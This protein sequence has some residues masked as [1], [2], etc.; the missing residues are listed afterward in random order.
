MRTI[1]DVKKAIADAVAAYHKIVHSSPAADVK[2]ASD[3]VKGL[4]AELSAIITEGAK[5]CPMCK[6]QPFGMEQPNGRSTE[7]EIG[8]LGCKPIEHEDGTIREPRVRGGMV[9]AH[10][11]EAWNGGPDFW[12]VQESS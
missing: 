5:P 4:R 3:V 1:K 10:A 6:E 9:P 7:F 11:V 12:L 8:C 2:K